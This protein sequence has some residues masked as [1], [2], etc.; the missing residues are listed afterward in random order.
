MDR[1]EKHSR[2]VVSAPEYGGV[3]GRL[4]DLM[5]VGWVCVCPLTAMA[6][7]PE[8]A[9]DRGQIVGLYC[10][11]IDSGGEAPA[12]TR[13]DVANDMIIGSY[14]FADPSQ[15]GGIARGSLTDCRLSPAGLLSCTWR[16]SYGSGSFEA[17]FSDDADRFS[18]HWS[19]APP[20]AA[21]TFTWTGR[22]P[23][24]AAADEVCL[25]PSG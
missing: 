14:G 24:T 11:L 9:V 5:L 21:A 19:P 3:M 25:S 1:N 4:F 12:F 20:D 15:K 18:G 8:P 10:G 6:G 16:D 7:P 17:Q 22:R 13:F 23:G 2:M